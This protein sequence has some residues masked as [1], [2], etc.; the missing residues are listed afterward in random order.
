MRRLAVLALIPALGAGH[1]AAG[2]SVQISFAPQSAAAVVAESVSV[3]VMVAN[4][5]GEPGLAAYDLLLT[6]DSDVV[7]LD[8]LSDSGFVSNQEN[9]VICVTGEIDNSDGI[10]NG[11][12]VGISLFGAPGVSATD[13][14]PLLHGSFTALAVGSSPLTLSGTL[15]GPEGTPISSTFEVGAINVAAG[16]SEAAVTPLATAGSLEL[17]AS[18]LGGDDGSS[19][20]PILTAAFALTAVGVVIAGAFLLLR[21]GFR[22]GT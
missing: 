20:P 2:A 18:G 7:R 12:C 8:S 16:P 21:R 19:L 6:F 10:V 1:V 15:S 17:P 22:G 13:A 3:D 14:V 9:L 4:I 11:T 5:S